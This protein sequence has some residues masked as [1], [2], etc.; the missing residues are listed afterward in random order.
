MFP[1]VIFLSYL[2]EETNTGHYVSVL[3]T[4]VNSNKH[5]NPGIFPAILI[6]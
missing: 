1:S 4:M 2:L 6:Y 3:K 5:E